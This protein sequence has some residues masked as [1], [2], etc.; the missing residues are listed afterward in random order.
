MSDTHTAGSMLAES[1]FTK[2][3][4]NLVLNK[5]EKLEHGCLILKENG[6]IYQF[7]MANSALKVELTIEQSRFYQLI[8]LDGS[9]GAAEA[10]MAGMWTVDDLTA[11]VRLFVLNEN[12]LDQIESG[13]TNVLMPVRKLAHWLNRNNKSNA[14]RNISAHYDLGNDFYQLFLDPSMM[15]SSAIYPNENT[16]LEQASQLKLKHI[17]DKLQLDDSH[18]LLEIGTGWGGFAIYAAQYTN[19]KVT[20]TTISDAQYRYAL[21][22]VKQAGLENKITVLKK[23]YRELTGLYDRIVS[24]EMIEAV[25]H[26][27]Y[28]T[29]FEQC[30]SLLKK[31]GQM[32]I[33]AITIAD[34]RYRYYLSH[35]DFIQKYIFPGG[36]L[37]S[38]EEL[39]KQVSHS[40]D[41]VMRNLEDIGLH[42]AQTLNDWRVR[43]FNNI[44]QVKKLGYSK[45]FQKMWEFYFCYCEGAFRERAIST[46]QVVLAKPQ[47]R[48]VSASSLSR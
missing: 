15:Y 40:T 22:A 43:F 8:M 5:L 45:E 32:L 21:E 6:N 46:V 33:Q 34:Q 24:I 3:A 29:Y 39:A 20:T 26:Q 13:Y 23:D 28:Q 19:C 27:Y 12:T 44:E 42:Y 9:I 1:P 37:P 31:N 16:S 48:S 14:K 11:L 47:N 38:I 10:Y 4:R 25:G 17:C 18:H 36:C 30:S 7:G 2:I 41:M 35:V